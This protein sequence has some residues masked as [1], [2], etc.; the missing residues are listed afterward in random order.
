MS[1]LKYLILT[2]CLI[3][4]SQVEATEPVDSKK[5]KQY[6]TEILAQ[7]EFKT[8][9]EETRL[10][11]I[12]ENSNEGISQE[13]TPHSFNFINV[14]AQIFELLLWI[15]LGIGIILLI[16]YSSRRWKRPQPTNQPKYSPHLVTEKAKTTLLSVNIPQQAWTLWQNGS[17]RA[18]ISLLYQ[19]A[20]A[21][22]I[23]RDGL[24]IEESATE[25]ECLRLVKYKQPL[26]LSKYFSAL[27][28]VWQNIAYAK[29]QPNNEE[30]QQLCEEWQQHFLR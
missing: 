7:P 23:T 30:M 11:Y 19:G 9:R 6:I 5:A 22:L 29:R 17:E 4:S 15:L 3:I 13:L 16:V 14:I 18:A 24:L 25:N 21:V 12:G 1:I 27:S 28:Q 2:V 8:T 26:E 10:R 20:L